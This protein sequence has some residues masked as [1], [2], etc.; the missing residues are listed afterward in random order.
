MFTVNA[1]TVPLINSPLLVSLG[2][3]LIIGTTLLAI[4]SNVPRTRE[5]SAQRLALEFGLL[6]IS[7]LIAGPLSEDNHYV[8]LAI[9]MLAMAV[10]LVNNGRSKPAPALMLMLGLLAVYAYLSLPSLLA[11]DNGNYAYYTAPISGLK[12]L[13]TGMHVY[14]LVLLGVLA[15][16]A[17]RLERGAQTTAS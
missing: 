14:G 15:T 16:A 1:W 3:V 11:L 2:R 12:V 4:I 5:H 7:M 9:P 17:L 13:L 6:V 8:Y 10:M